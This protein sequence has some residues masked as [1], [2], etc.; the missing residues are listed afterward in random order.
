MKIIKLIK[1]N[2][3]K[4]RYLAYNFEIKKKKKVLAPPR[5]VT[6]GNSYIDKLLA[7]YAIRKDCC[8]KI[9]SPEKHKKVQ[10]DGSV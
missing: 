4:L 9:Y 10:G 8:L 5:Q 3:N 1:G 6:D 7:L 2:K